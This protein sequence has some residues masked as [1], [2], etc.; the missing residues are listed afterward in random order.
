MFNLLI[1]KIKY[2]FLSSLL[3]M[4]LPHPSFAQKEFTLMGF[5][6]HTDLEGGCWFLQVKKDKYELTAS[7]E[8]LQTCHVAGR[9][10][11][12]RV[13]QAPMMAS[14]CMIGH[15]VE[16]VEVLDTLFHPH[17]PPV[18]HKIVKGI[19]HKTKDG[20][21]YVQA[22]DKRR[23][24]LQA[25][26]PKKFMRVGAHYNRM[27]MV[28]PGSEGDCNMDDVITINQLE[29]DMKPKEAKEKKSDPR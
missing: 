12:L 27:S 22:T 6:Q 25:P 11:T 29:P 8:I 24:E 4:M 3:V 21:W 18:F 17:N 2:I 28:I 1:M 9:W 5:M 20:C 7:P 23:Y 10:L 13:R 15:M 26:I 16:V 19:I 14:V